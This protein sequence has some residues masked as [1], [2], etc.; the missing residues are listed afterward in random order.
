M[1]ERISIVTDEISQDLGECESFLRE[2]D[3][4]AVELRTISGRR[5]PDVAAADQ[6]RLLSW[7][8]A[9]EPLVVAMSPGL[10]KC[11]AD[12]RAEI[13]RHLTEVLPR[14]I[15]LA[16][17]LD[18]ENLIAFAFAAPQG[19]EP[20]AHAL[21]ALARAA[22]ACAQAALPLLVE[23]EPEHLAWSAASTAALIRRAG[24]PNLFVNWD[25][26]NGNEFATAELQAALAALTPYLRNVHVKNG[27]LHPGESYARC[28]ALSAGEIDWQAHLAQLLE[29]G[30]DGHFAVETH[31]LPARESS[32]AVLAELRDLLAR[33]G[34]VWPEED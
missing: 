10:F 33:V 18:A 22:D 23:N 3:L 17:A 19:G 13:E 24:H 30:Y 34:Y 21:D 14:A 29:I 31:H 16:L 26:T 7:T 4:H 27:R 5:V 15:D 12:D 1:L 6:E 32:S 11:R 20:P 28:C 9:G 2:H 8:R 25:P